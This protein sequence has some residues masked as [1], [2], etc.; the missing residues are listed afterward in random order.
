[1]SPKNRRVFCS[2]RR[3][4]R[5][6]DQRSGWKRCHVCLTKIR[7]SAVGRPRKD[8]RDGAR[9][10]ADVRGAG[11]TTATTNELL[12]APDTPWLEASEWDFAPEK[13]RAA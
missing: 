2:C 7:G 3:K 1:M 10:Q 6:H 13:K 8:K 12:P 11:A 9:G 4:I 5:V